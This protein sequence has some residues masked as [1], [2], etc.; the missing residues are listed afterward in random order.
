[1]KTRTLSRYASG[2]GLA[3]ALLLHSPVASGQAVTF[4][5]NLQSAQF[6]LYTDPYNGNEIKLGG[7][8]GIYPVPGQAD[9]FYVI[10]DRGPA[11]DFTDAGGKLFKAFAIPEFGPHLL[12]VRL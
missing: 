2:A 7:F 4:D 3:G 6:T 8:S 10:T 11:P 5:V 12:T 9:S 1:M